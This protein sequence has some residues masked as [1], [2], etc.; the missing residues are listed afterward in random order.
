MS[1]PADPKIPVQRAAQPGLMV[2]QAAGER[3]SVNFAW[4]R[5]ATS[6]SAHYFGLKISETVRVGDGHG[7]AIL[8][9]P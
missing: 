8:R 1:F 5:L 4:I 2:A 7:K 3:A 6:M 9:V